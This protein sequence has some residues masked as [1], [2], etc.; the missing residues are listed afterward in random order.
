ME[1]RPLATASTPAAAQRT[2]QGRCP[3]VDLVPGV[4]EFQ[5]V[6]R[7]VGAVVDED[8]VED[9]DD[10]A[11]DQVDEQGKILT[12]IRLPGNSA[13]RGSPGLM[14]PVS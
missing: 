12:V 1:M 10:T 13:T 5:H 14:S 2:G 11:L 4:T 8:E 3:E 7:S 9:A 6:D